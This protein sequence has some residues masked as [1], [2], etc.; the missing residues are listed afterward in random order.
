[1]AIAPNT[2]FVSSNVLTAAQ[3]N[4]LPFGIC[5]LATSSTTYTITTST[6]I[7]TGMTATF[8][9]IANRYYKVSYY[10]PTIQT[11]SPS[12]SYVNVTIRETNAAGTQRAQNYVQTPAAS[13]L[14]QSNTASFISTFS[15]G[16]VTLVGCV[17]SNTTTGTPVAERGATSLAYIVVED[18]GPA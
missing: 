12:G 10:E 14:Y 3:M 4:A 8:T 15:A 2:T 11:P 6:V 18:I 1:M 17:S 5:A 16:S 13:S 9:A 7:A